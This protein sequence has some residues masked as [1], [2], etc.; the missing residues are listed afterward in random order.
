MIR[1][2]GISGI[3]TPFKNA[4]RHRCECIA[5]FHDANCSIRR[6]QHDQSIIFNRRIKELTA[7][8]YAFDR[9]L[10]AAT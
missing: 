5:R 9:Y 2:A 4:L 8:G 10:L 6:P 1:Q 3:D 7:K